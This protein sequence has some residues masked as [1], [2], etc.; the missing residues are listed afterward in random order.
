M[1]TISSSIVVQ[2]HQR[3][4]PLVE[5]GPWVLMIDSVCRVKSAGDDIIEPHTLAPN[6]RRF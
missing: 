2:P 3:H 5:C 4:F 1:L 6:L